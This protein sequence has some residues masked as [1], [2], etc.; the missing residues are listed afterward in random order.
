MA[1][2]H[3]VAREFLADRP[4]AFFLDYLRRFADLPFLVTLEDRASA[5]VAR[6]VPHSRGPRRRQRGCRLDDRFQGVLVRRGER[7]RDCPRFG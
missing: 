3:V 7:W 5:A 1:M 6:A 2:G 4:V